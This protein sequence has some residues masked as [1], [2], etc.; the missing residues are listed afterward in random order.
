MVAPPDHVPVNPLGMHRYLYTLCG[1]WYHPSCCTTL[2]G[3]DPGAWNLLMSYR[4]FCD[5]CLG[6]QM[7]AERVR[8]DALLMEMELEVLWSPHT[9]TVL[10]CQTTGTIMARWL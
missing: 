5:P 10:L 2:Y 1:F 7:W 4:P 8:P 9:Y 3:I 6:Q